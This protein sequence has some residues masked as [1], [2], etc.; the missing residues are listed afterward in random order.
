MNRFRLLPLFL[1]T[2]LL[3]QADNRPLVALNFND[4]TEEGH[5][6][7]KGTLGGE[8][9][10]DALKLPTPDVITGITGSTNDKALQL[11]G[12]QV[13]TQTQYPKHSRLTLEVPEDLKPMSSWSFSM[14][15][16]TAEREQWQHVL[17]GWGV[18]AKGA[19]STGLMVALNPDAKGQPQF[20]V[21][22][23]GTSFYS[24][25]FEK[26]YGDAWMFVAMVFQEGELIMVCPAKCID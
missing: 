17:M 12:E 11:G 15:F 6:P 10:L 8:G 24:A 1:L 23:E 2:G 16:T 19:P 21:D 25:P 3:L 7:N 26:T 18:Q 14:W 9:K 4:A 22:V 20:R 5:F 13:S